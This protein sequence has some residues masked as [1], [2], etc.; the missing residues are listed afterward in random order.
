MQFLLALR[1]D[2]IDGEERETGVSPAKLDV[3]PKERGFIV[4][5]A[6]QEEVLAHEAVGGFLTHSG[7]NSTME[8]IWIGVPMLCSP[9]IA[10]QP[11]TSRLVGE[12][13]K[14]GF[15]TKDKYDRITVEK[16]I[17]TLME[18]GDQR[19]EILESVKKFVKLAGL[20]VSEGGSSYNNLEKLIQNL[21]NM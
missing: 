17:R 11:I 12:V 16:M 7:W 5:W 21:T 3:G 18:E 1:P 20:A 15:D 13:W 8:G 19:E 4:E 2:M 6:P 10:D 14:I 9:Q